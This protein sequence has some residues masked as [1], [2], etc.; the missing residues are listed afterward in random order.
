MK[1]NLFQ[2]NCYILYKKASATIFKA[3]MLVL[4][5]IPLISIGQKTLTEVFINDLKKFVFTYDE[6]YNTTA[7]K[8]YEKATVEDDWILSD[9]ETF[10]WLSN[11]KLMDKVVYRKGKAGNML[12]EFRIIYNYNEN[13]KVFR[14]EMF[15]HREGHWQYDRDTEFHYT[16]DQKLDSVFYYKKEGQQVFLSGLDTYDYDKNGRKV[17]FM[18]HDT[19]DDTYEPYPVKKTTFQ[20]K[21]GKLHQKI[22]YYKITWGD[23]KGQWEKNRKEEYVYGPEGKQRSNTQYR[24]KDESWLPA[25]KTLRYTDSQGRKYKQLLKRHIDNQWQDY[26]K[27]EFSF[28]DVANK[29]EYIYPY[30]EQEEGENPF[31]IEGGIPASASRS[32][33]KPKTGQW[34]TKEKIRFI[35]E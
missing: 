3:A 13:G 10:S 7:K 32:L 12:P 33:F 17:L 23:R 6:N 18:S 2:S 35:W 21:N 19:K 4:L 5:F 20:Y 8:E 14:K 31:D 30:L 15:Y 28:M 29:N 16:N 34:E 26:I 25:T 27:T 24:F 9:K 22:K 11:D 1:I